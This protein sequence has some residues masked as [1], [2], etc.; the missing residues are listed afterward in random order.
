MEHR[1]R[2]LLVGNWKMNGMI[3]SL[4]ELA[5]TASRSVDLSLFVDMVICPPLTLVRSAVEGVATSLL[6][7]GAQ[8]CSDEQ[9]GA[10]TGDVS[11]AM[12][13]NCG[14][15]WVIIGHSERRTLRSETSAVVCRKVRQALSAGV[16]PIVC[17]GETE[18][19]MHEG[20]T[21]Q[22]LSEQLT[23]SLPSEAGQGDF[24]VAYEPVWAIG[25]GKTPTFDEIAGV[26]QFIRN[27]LDAQFADHGPKTRLLYG[28]S[29]KAENAREIITCENV[30]GALVGGASLKAA[31]FLA[32]ADA[33]CVS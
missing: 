18:S 9:T 8:D 12:L 21:L 29:V 17:I 27:W 26:H 3:S 11:A 19:E 7:I 23:A 13:A 24:V 30:S 5:Q 15:K 4:D 31:S 16:T 22:V 33:F 28:G 1:V 14:A 25:S 6:E 10:F 20:R 32:I 2:P